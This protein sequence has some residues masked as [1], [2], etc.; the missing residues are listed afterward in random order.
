MPIR[1][2]RRARVLAGLAVPTLAAAATYRTYCV[3]GSK[4][5]AP[6]IPTTPAPTDTWKEGK[7]TAVGAVANALTSIPCTLLVHW[8]TLLMSRVLMSHDSPNSV[9]KGEFSKGKLASF[10]ASFSSGFLENLGRGW[11]KELLRGAFQAL[12]PRKLQE[13][14]GTEFR[15]T[16]PLEFNSIVGGLVTLADLA[17]IKPLETVTTVA[18][19]SKTASKGLVRTF[20]ELPFPQQWYGGTGFALRQ[21]IGLGGPMVTNPLVTKYLETIKDP[22]KKIMAFFGAQALIT[23]IMLAATMLPQQLKVMAE[24]VAGTNEPHTSTWQL[25]KKIRHGVR[26]RIRENNEAF[27]DLGRLSTKLSGQMVTLGGS[28]GE[29]EQAGLNEMHKTKD[30]LVAASRKL[31]KAPPSAVVADILKKYAI[32]GALRWPA[33]YVGVIASYLVNEVVMKEYDKPASTT[34]WASRVTA[35]NNYT[36]APKGFAARLEAAQNPFSGVL[37]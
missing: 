6:T 28:S 17:F 34:A 1:I 24:A 36:P 27:Q 20:L 37:R 29:A 2:P 25:I 31:Y 26:L 23:F 18:M 30:D 10:R 4:S 12:I 15:R 5:M 13:Y 3:D 14:T 11:W 7:R 19:R 32:A 9:L 8:P 33:L 16:N 21:L 22:Q 35:A